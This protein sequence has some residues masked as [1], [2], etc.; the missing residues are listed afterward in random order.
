M[1][2][3]IILH[4]ASYIDDKAIKGLA[5]GKKSL[6]FVQI[7]KCPNVTDSGLK[8][9][10][11]LENLKNLVLFDL[12]EVVDLNECKQYLQTHLPKCKIGGN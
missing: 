5:Y 4:N 2:H 1:V 3:K 10:K 7:S 11:V 12:L 9:L 6:T 8:E